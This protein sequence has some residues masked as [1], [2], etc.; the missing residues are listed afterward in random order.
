VPKKLIWQS[1]IDDAIVAAVER[2]FG[3]RLDGYKYVVRNEDEPFL[4][5]KLLGAYD[6]AS[7]VRKFKRDI[8]PILKAAIK[9]VPVKT[10]IR[11]YN[12]APSDLEIEIA[13]LWL[14]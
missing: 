9:K 10:A 1:E 13:F 4:Y 12:V 6:D 3:D 11:A 8:A 7:A 5:F 2:K 14:T